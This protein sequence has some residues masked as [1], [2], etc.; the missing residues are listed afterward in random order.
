M[1]RSVVCVSER[2][3][4]CCRFSG[5]ALAGFECAVHRAALPVAR[6]RLACEEQRVIE[7]RRETGARITASNGNVT[8]RATCERI[9][10]PVVHDATLELRTH[11]RRVAEQCP[12]TRQRVIDE[13]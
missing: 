8:V 11:E 10:A 5:G 7:G 4:G 1:L 6:R 12:Q 2:R 9:A 13:F 3:E